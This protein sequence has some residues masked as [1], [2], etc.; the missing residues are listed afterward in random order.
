MKRPILFNCLLA[1]GML[2][3]ATIGSAQTVTMNFIG[4]DGNSSG[5]YYVFPYYFT[6]NSGTHTNLLICDTFGNEITAGESWG[7]TMLSV[8]RLTVNN[9]GTL[10]F[11]S[12]GV[13][14]YLEACYLYQEELAAYNNSNSDP[15]GLYNWAIWDLFAGGTGPST[16]VFGA[17]SS[18]ETAIENDLSGAEALGGS[19]VPSDFPGMYI[20]TPTNTDAAQEFFGDCTIP[21]PGTLALVALA[22]GGLALIRKRK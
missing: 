20:I 2:V 22:V 18:Q 16:G 3:A 21:E 1:C 6:I 5:G 9:V 19:L 4:G 8:S 14:T 13:T 12:E 7:A 10:E 17:G 15:Q 11:G